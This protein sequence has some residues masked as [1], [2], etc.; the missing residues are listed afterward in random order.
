MLRTE[1]D[2]AGLR[3]LLAGDNDI[4]QEVA[5]GLLEGVGVEVIVVEYGRAAVTAVH[6]VSGQLDE[7]LKGQEIER[8]LVLLSDLGRELGE[9]AGIVVRLP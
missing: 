4:K 8:A 6:E 9:L 1:Q 7:A 5:M 2:L 3:V